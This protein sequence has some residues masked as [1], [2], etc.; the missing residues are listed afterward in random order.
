MLNGTRSSHRV[1][2]E[3][4]NGEKGKLSYILMM[5]LIQVVV[6]SEGLLEGHFLQRR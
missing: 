6:V 4:N 3:E 5:Y 1:R 2:D